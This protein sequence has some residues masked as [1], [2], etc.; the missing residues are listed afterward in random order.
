MMLMLLV[1]AEMGNMEKV[2]LYRVLLG[3]CKDIQKKNLGIQLLSA[4]VGIR[5][6]FSFKFENH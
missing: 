6:G 5:E 1:L 2:D 4:E 3:T